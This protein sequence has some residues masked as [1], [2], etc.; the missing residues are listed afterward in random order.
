LT[1]LIDINI[2]S[3]YSFLRGSINPQEACKRDQRGAPFIEEGIA[4]KDPP[5]SSCGARLGSSLM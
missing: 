4:V 3:E 5:S 2:P 1:T